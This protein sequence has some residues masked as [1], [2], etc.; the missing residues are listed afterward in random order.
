MKLDEGAANKKPGKPFVAK[1]QLAMGGGRG[2][3]M[4]YNKT[5]TFQV[6]KINKIKSKIEN[7]KS[8]IE[9]LQGKATRQKK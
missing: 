6:N 8:K 3:M 2:A 7:R 9:N 5:R 1:I 4:V